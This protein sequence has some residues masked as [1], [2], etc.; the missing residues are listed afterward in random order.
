MRLSV[1]IPALNEAS[2][3]PRT[4][5]T[6]H[7]ACP[8]AQIVV[9]DGGSC[10]GTQALCRRQRVT[11]LESRRGR[12]C[13][14]NAGAALADEPVLLF[15]HA[16][17]L[18]P[19][20]AQ[21]HILQALSEPTHIAG[22]FYLRFDY[23]H[24]LLR[25]YSTMSRLNWPWFTFGDQGLFL[26]RETFRSM[27]GFAE[28]PLMEDLEIQSRLR[29]LGRFVKLKHP[30]VTSSRRFVSSGIGTQQLRNICLVAAYQLGV[31]PRRL[32][33]YYGHHIH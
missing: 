32:A 10:D 12:A 17:T 16:D 31:S 6:V 3:L 25:F 18:L 22:S 27:G 30:V 20:A 2:A 5:A 7:S 28:I 4:L 8:G 19:A 23:N 9:A 33:R 26:R 13:Q 24:P 14:M 11:V 21:S 29:K 15:L 1:I